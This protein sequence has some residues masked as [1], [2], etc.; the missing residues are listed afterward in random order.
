M[1][2]F[3]PEIGMNK[4]F[5]VKTMFEFKE[6]RIHVSHK[7]KMYVRGATSAKLIPVCP[8]VN[9]VDDMNIF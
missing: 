8:P 2:G 6:S 7:L 1:F 9:V 4:G 3:K 5:F